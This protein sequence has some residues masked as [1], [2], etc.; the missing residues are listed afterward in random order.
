[1]KAANRNSH[2]QIKCQ[3]QY[4]EIQRNKQKRN[5]KNQSIF[6]NHNN[7]VIHII[8]FR[9]FTL[10]GRLQNFPFLLKDI[11]QII[12]WKCLC[13]CCIWLSPLG[14]QILFGVFVELAKNSEFFKDVQRKC[15]L[16][17]MCY[18]FE[19]RRTPFFF[20][21][22]PWG[23]LHDSNLNDQYLTLRL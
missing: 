16:S 21:L 7:C 6:F 2:C 19:I 1:M 9:H 5:K 11:N 8:I 18:L 20:C 23:K 22:S 3:T 12:K 17:Q 13:F 4:R 15:H 10:S 14:H